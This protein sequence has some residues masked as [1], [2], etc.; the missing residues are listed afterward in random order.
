[1]KVHREGEK[2]PVTIKN[3]QKQPIRPIKETMLLN[4]QNIF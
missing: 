3:E 2:H 4:V 1:M